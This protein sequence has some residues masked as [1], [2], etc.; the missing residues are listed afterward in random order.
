MS[1]YLKSRYN[2][3]EIYDCESYRVLGRI[4]SS[5]FVFHDIF[6]WDDMP[7]TIMIRQLEP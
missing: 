4:W 1:K 6:K 7:V 5:K 3:Y 2:L